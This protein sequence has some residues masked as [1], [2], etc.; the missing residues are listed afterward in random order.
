MDKCSRLKPLLHRECGRRCRSGFIRE[1][2]SGPFAAKAAPTLLF[3]IG[4]QMYIDLLVE[5]RDLGTFEGQVVHQAF[6]AKD[7]TDHRVLDVV[8]IDGLTGAQVDQGN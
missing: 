5:F 4:S 3:T 1:P 7:K 8:R 6:R 2:A